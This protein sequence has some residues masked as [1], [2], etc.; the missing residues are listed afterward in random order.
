MAHINGCFDVCTYPKIGHSQKHSMANYAQ[1]GKNI[2]KIRPSHKSKEKVAERAKIGARYYQQIELGNAHPSLDVI[3][4]LREEF[5]T[6][7]NTLLDGV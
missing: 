3:A 1:L 5:N 7:W 6:D 4:K 2:Q